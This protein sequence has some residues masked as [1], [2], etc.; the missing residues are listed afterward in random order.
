MINKSFSGQIIL[1]KLILALYRF[2]L[3]IILPQGNPAL[4]PFN[5]E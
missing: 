4:C 5:A 2:L 3:K 1:Q